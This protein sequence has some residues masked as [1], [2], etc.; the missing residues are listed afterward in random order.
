VRA[1]IKPETIVCL[2]QFGKA[3][4]KPYK[5]A[6]RPQDREFAQKWFARAQRLLADGLLQP[7]PHRRMGGMSEIA[8]GMEMVQRGEVTGCKLVY[9]VVHE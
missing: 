2:T 7:Q 1:G 9:T 4:S 6:A 3:I 5:R 8:A